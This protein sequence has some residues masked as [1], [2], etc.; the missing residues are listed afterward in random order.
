LSVD[1]RSHVLSVA[2]ALATRAGTMSE[3]WRLELC[4][5]S[6]APSRTCAQLHGTIAL[7]TLTR[8]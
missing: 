3:E 7:A 1:G 6:M 4:A 2:S 8:V 5:E